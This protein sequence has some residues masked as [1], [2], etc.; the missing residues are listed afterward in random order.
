MRFKALLAVVALALGFTG[1]AT[2]QVQDGFAS[3]GTL[4][5]TVFDP[6][7]SETY[8]VDL[9]TT[10]SSFLANPTGFSA[11]A[12]LSSWLAGASDLGAILF[13]VAVINFN[14][15]Q[16]PAGLFGALVTANGVPDTPDSFS[17]VNSLLLNMST[18]VQGVNASIANTGSIATGGSGYFQ[19]GFTWNRNIGGQLGGT[20]TGGTIGSAIQLYSILSDG[21]DSSGNTWV[22]SAVNRAQFVLDAQGNL[23]IIPIPAAGWLLL[24]ALAG[25]VGIARRRKVVAAAA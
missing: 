16:Q 2:A 9:G 20:I 8:N 6:N 18:Y 19:D 21:S 11:D 13:D 7:R 24:S 1:T 3:E 10:I 12:G 4:F 17:S 15:S 14:A 22:V 5:L 23:S 25:L